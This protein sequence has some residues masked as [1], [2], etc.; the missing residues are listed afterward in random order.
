MINILVTGGSGTVGSELLELLIRNPDYAVTAFSHETSR[1]RRFFKR[2]RG[3]LEVVFGDIAQPDEIAKVCHRKD[4][5]MHL[6]A[7]IPPLADR[8]P[9]ATIRVNVD[10]TRNLIQALQKY[11]PEAFLLHASSVSVYGDRLS[12]PGIRTT[13]PLTPSEGD[14]Y[15]QTKYEAE[16]LVQ[17]SSLAWSIFRLSAIMGANNHKISGL[18]FHMPLNTPIEITTPLDTARAFVNALDQKEMIRGRIFN[19]GGGASCR[20][21]F[22]DLLSRSFDIFGLGA[23]DFPEKAFA[24]KNFHC[25]L[26]SDGDDLEEILHFRN[27]DLDAYFRIVRDSVRPGL[28][29]LA[30]LFGYPVK[31]YLLRLSEPYKAFTSGDPAGMKRWFVQ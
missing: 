6:A 24:E 23:L 7:I 25:G 14:V 12:D 20:I 29:A 8:N 22:R 19:L 4:F 3:K 16:K 2:F 11:S 28:K 10:G 17:V 26:Y 21:V 5:V 13:D 18:M 30:V 9:E 15:G 27:D 31:K 1:S